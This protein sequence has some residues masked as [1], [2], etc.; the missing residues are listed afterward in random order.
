MRISPAELTALLMAVSFAAGLNVYAAVGALGLLSRLHIVTVPL[1]LD[2]VTNW[3]VIG[4]C[5]VLFLVE[6]F[7]RQSA[8]I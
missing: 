4:V 8:G 6:F 1:T 5:G 2:L 3:Y 7:C